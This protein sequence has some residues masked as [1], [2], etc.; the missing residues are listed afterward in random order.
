MEKS[1]RFSVDKVFPIAMIQVRSELKGDVDKL[2][3]YIC[4]NKKTFD[5]YSDNDI[6]IAY[7]RC[8]FVPSSIPAYIEKGENLEIIPFHIKK[9]EW[10]AI[11]TCRQITFKTM[12]SSPNAFFYRN[13][14]PGEQAL[15]GPWSSEEIEAFQQR[16]S[17]FKH[18]GLHDKLWGLFSVPLKRYG[19]TCSCFSKDF[20]AKEKKNKV[21]YPD[22]PKEEIEEYL[23]KEAIDKI[24]SAMKSCKSLDVNTLLPK[25]S[26]AQ[27]QCQHK[28]SVSPPPIPTPIQPVLPAVRRPKKETNF[29][30]TL[31]YSEL[32]LTK[33]DFEE[34]RKSSGMKIKINKKKTKNVLKE[35]APHPEEDGLN[36]AR[37]AMDEITKKPMRFPT[38]NRDGYVLDY[39]TWDAIMTKKLDC[40]FMISALS[41][42]DLIRIT[43]E[44]FDSLKP[45]M[46]NVYF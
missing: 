3:Q 27:R 32:I 13:R 24:I 31:D 45:F 28:S 2:N 25:E 16:L 17:F 19:Y 5:K 10:E 36:L 11:T 7:E 40:P 22:I 4:E 26:G 8:G 46:R 41:R 42:T 15:K 35:V 21:E 1:P 37:G 43:E 14:P 30:K 9:D 39:S 38:I 33:K 23:K 44:N 18:F 6:W 20:V 34:S 29:T 12:F